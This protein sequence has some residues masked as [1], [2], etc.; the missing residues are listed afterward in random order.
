MKYLLVLILCVIATAKMSF[1]SAFG[2]KDIRNSADAVCFNGLVFL[3]AAILFSGDLF[4]CPW[5]VWIYAL[6]GAAFSVSFQLTYAK[7]LSIGNVSLTVLISNL[8]LVINVLVSYLFFGDSI[9][10]VRLIG[11]LL[12]IVVFALSVDLK[13]GKGTNVKT[14]AVLAILTMFANAALGVTQKVLGESAFGGYNRAYTA[15]TYLTAAVMS[16]AVY[17]VLRLRGEKK[18]FAI[19]KR[20]ILLSAAT[21]I[22][23]GVFVVMNVY[24]LG[25]VEGTFLF[26]TFAGGVIILS[27]LSGVVLFKDKFSIKQIIGVL[28][29]IVAVVLMNF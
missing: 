18:T 17:G 4:G 7:A 3:F 11:I 8:S 6:L 25:V 24:A 21:G 13:A 10:G 27:T 5:Q 1:Q 28:I 12:T 15:A 26:P 23:L 9:S 19:G 29:G 2:K 14:W 20:A 16:C 22:T